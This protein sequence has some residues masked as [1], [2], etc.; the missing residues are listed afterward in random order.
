MQQTLQFSDLSFVG[1]I[2]E[3]IV[4]SV[5]N[6][7]ILKEIPIINSLV[8][9][10]KCVKNLYD[11]YFIK[12]LISFLFPMRNISPEE[13][14]KAIQTWQDDENYRGKVGDTL[15]GMISRC[16]DSIKSVWLSHLFIELVVRKGYSRLFMRSEKVL[17]S[18]SVMDVQAFL[19]MSP[20]Q[21][22]YISETD[23]EPFIGSGLYQSPKKSAFYHSNNKIEQITCE[24][25]EVG[26]LIYN[27][28]NGINIEEISELPL[29]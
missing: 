19:N 26:F 11:A 13:R 4:D 23:Y 27:I 15:L 10:G 9:V 17:S 24:I 16:D 29:F 25:T 8:G 20:K 3:I 2:G 18:L 6:D 1:D 7:N 14:S 28:L 21:Y 22:N 5:I 12:K